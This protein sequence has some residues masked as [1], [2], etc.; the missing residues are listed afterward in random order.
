ML[1][2][3]ISKLRANNEA[4]IAEDLKLRELNKKI[5]L[6]EG[7]L[8][9]I[10]GSRSSMPTKKAVKVN[11]EVLKEGVY[12][13][14]F[15]YIIHGVNGSPVMIFELFR[16]QKRWKLYATACAPGLVA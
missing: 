3:Y 15:S 4:I 9:R 1:K 13:L 14:A 11:I 6:L 2:Y 16:N 7:D 12:D 5:S 10:R 8:G